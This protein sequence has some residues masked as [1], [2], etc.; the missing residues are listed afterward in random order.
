MPNEITTVYCK[1][2]NRQTKELCNAELFQTDGEFIYTGGQKVNPK[3][4]AQTIVCYKCVRKLKWK[5]RKKFIKQ[6]PV[7]Q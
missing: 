7:T 2:R 5:R 6:P 3:S 1:G 4:D